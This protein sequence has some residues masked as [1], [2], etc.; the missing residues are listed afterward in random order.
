MEKRLLKKIEVLR[1]KLYHYGTTHSLIDE[2][3]VKMSQELDYLLN[4]YHRITQY[5]QLTFW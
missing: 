4:Q 1:Q 3:V 2:K 5:T